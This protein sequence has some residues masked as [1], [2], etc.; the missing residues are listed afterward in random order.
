MTIRTSKSVALRKTMADYATKE[1]LEELGA[2][3]PTM[4]D[5]KAPYL[6]DGGSKPAIKMKTVAVGI[7]SFPPPTPTPEVGVM[8]GSQVDTA[9][10]NDVFGQ[11]Q[12]QQI[13]HPLVS[14]CHCSP[15]HLCIYIFFC[16][17]LQSKYIIYWCKALIFL[18]LCY[19]DSGLV[20]WV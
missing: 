20:F 3:V 9:L 15:T 8:S 17:V 13:L 16:F 12:K 11:A 6:D 4:S 7:E 14:S 5:E 2:K 18:I 19:L 1:F 10:P